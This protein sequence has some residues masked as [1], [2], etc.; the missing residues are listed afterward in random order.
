MFQKQSN[1]F[2]SAEYLALEE[3]A[4]YKSEYYR[5]EIFAMAGGSY[6]HNMI[7]GNLY[8]ALNQFVASRSCFAFTSDMKLFV[9]QYDLYTYPDAMVI[10]GQIHFAKNRTDT[11]TNPKILIEV[12]SKS[13]QDYDRGL[14]FE[15]Y[16]SLKSCQ[17][18][19]LIDQERVHLEYYHKLPDNRWALTEFKTAEASLT[20]ES[21]DFEIPISQIYHKVDWFSV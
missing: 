9:E 11:V 14:K 17:D 19:I 8:A 15:A 13:T 21:L 3:A 1:Y 16:R 18:Y 20:I 12:L 4:D 6:N 5:G 10:C 2:T 7:A